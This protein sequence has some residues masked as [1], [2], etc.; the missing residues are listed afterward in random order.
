MVIFTVIKQQSGITLLE[1]LIGLAISTLIITLATYNSNWVSI[2]N[3]TQAKS[4]IEQGVAKAR[5]ASLMNP[6]G[7]TDI[8]PIAIMYLNNNTLEIK[9]QK[10]NNNGNCD[11]SSTETETI[12]QAQLPDQISV[13]TD[14]SVEPDNSN[15]FTCLAFNNRAQYI[16][17]G[18]A[19][20]C[21]APSSL[22]TGCPDTTSSTT[23]VYAA[24]LV[25]Y[26][27]QNNQ[28]T[29]S[30]KLCINANLN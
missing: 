26:N 6:C 23:V 15:L 30:N 14:S 11:N 2:A 16:N 21:L 18:A 25:Y 12:W 22:P 27:Q 10:I 20:N 19:S 13:K 4:M 3:L 5:S 24:L 7:L 29:G 17:S 1:L 8:E 9:R 28:D